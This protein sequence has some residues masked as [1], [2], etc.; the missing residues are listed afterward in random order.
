[1]KQLVIHANTNQRIVSRKLQMIVAYSN[2]KGDQLD[3]NSSLKIW[4]CFTPCDLHIIILINT[5]KNKGNPE[6]TQ[7]IASF[8]IFIIT[9]KNKILFTNKQRILTY[10]QFTCTH[11]D[12]YMK[13][14]LINLMCPGHLTCTTTTQNI[15][16]IISYYDILE[17]HTNNNH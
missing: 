7:P 3:R 16:T 5:S 15:K 8:Y 14:W 11:E 17:S 10:T 1:M 9:I 6:L 2:Q 13:E 4:F 12:I